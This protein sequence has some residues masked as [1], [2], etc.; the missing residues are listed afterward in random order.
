MKFWYFWITLFF[1]GN[2]IILWGKKSVLP[3]FQSHNWESHLLKEYSLKIR[4]R[5][6]TSEQKLLTLSYSMPGCFCLICEDLLGQCA[7]STWR[8][9]GWGRGPSRQSLPQPLPTSSVPSCRSLHCLLCFGKSIIFLS[10][11]IRF[12]PLIKMAFFGH[13]STTIALVRKTRA[14]Q[15]G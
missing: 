7:S 14:S 10:C 4:S 6:E 3:F 2:G 8:Q 12:A 1:R 13:Y 9:V 5:G 11:H 15:Q